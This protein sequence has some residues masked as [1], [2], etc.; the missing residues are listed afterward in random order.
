LQLNDISAG[1]NSTLSPRCSLIIHPN[2]CTTKRQPAQLTGGN[3]LFVKLTY[4]DDDLRRILAN[5]ASATLKLDITTADIIEFAY[6]VDEDD[7]VTGV[8]IEFEAPEKV[9]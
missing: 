2:G 9:E 1:K 8:S 5:H 3:F 4:N 7:C 6:E